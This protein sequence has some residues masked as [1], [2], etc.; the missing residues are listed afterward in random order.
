MVKKLSVVIKTDESDNE[1]TPSLQGRCDVCK[2]KSRLKCK[3]CGVKLDH[4]K[5]T[6]SLMWTIGTCK[7]VY[8]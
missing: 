2:G 4:D 7:Y 1:S 3:K 5:G 8:K 6:V